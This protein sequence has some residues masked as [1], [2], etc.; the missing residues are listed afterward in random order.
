MYTFI[1]KFSLY[2]VWTGTKKKTEWDILSE[3]R[4]DLTWLLLFWQHLR[5]TWRNNV[6]CP[7]QL[8]NERTTTS[9][10]LQ[11][12]SIC[13]SSEVFKDQELV[14]LDPEMKKCWT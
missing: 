9:L 2:F 3:N 11:I 12:S 7:E 6:S 1:Y 4:F 10:V 5:H 14:G 13:F 8:N